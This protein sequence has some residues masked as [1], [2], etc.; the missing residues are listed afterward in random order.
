MQACQ[1]IESASVTL[2]LADNKSLD[3]TTRDRNQLPLDVWIKNLEEE[4]DAEDLTLQCN[5]FPMFQKNRKAER[6][7]SYKYHIAGK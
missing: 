2:I 4:S 7:K 6:K 3:A 1:P 5:G